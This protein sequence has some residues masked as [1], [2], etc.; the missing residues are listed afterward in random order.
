MLDTFLGTVR[1]AMK[2]HLRS[3]TY[4][5]GI[6]IKL[7]SITGIIVANGLDDMLVNYMKINVGF[8]VS[9]MFAVAL[10][11]YEALSI[12]E[13]MH[14]MGIFTGKLQ[15]ILDKFFDDSKPSK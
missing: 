3:R 1:S 11:G 4:L 13:N 12:L 7:L 15:D 9:D 14:Q 6:Y 8:D 10:V 5:K 2:S